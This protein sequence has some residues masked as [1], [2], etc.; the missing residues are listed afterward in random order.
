M[1]SIVNLK[2]FILR[3]IITLIIDPEKNSSGDNCAY[4]YPTY[5]EDTLDRDIETF[6]RTRGSSIEEW[7]YQKVKWR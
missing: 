2:M 7:F 5:P 4:F 3:Y 1:F 6:G